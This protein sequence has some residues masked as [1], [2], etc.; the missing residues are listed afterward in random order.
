MDWLRFNSSHSGKLALFAVARD[1]EVGID[2]EWIRPE[3]AKESVPERF[4]CPNEVSELRA[5]PARLQAAAFFQCWTR[6]EAYVKARGE[7]FRMSLNSF[8]VSSDSVVTDDKNSNWSLQSFVPADG[9]VA[10]LAA[11]GQDCRA[12]FIWKR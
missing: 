9:Y 3:I 12:R 4:F 8:E 11:E 7:G 1:R 6:K 5:L 2:V 10:A